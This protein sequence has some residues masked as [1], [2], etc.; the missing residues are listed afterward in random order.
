MLLLTS[1]C[2]SGMQ[3]LTV[4]PAMTSTLSHVCL[5]A[6]IRLGVEDMCMIHLHL[7]QRL[8]SI[9]CTRI[10]IILGGMHPITP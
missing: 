6:A 7:C 8:S 3:Q 2:Q 5:A 9:W 10:Q 1:L 4:M